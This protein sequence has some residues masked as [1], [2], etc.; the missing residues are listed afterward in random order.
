MKKRNN[1]IQKQN[2]FK[3]KVTKNGPYLATGG[4]A[5]SEQHIRVD[6]E[7]QCHGWKEGRIF[8]AQEH[9][10]LCRCGHSRS[11]PFC[12]GAHVRTDFDG[13]EDATHKT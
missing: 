5:M 6:A 2:R 7:G 13:T 11:K 8:Q 3:I 4:I 10:A 9:C 12:D 1:D